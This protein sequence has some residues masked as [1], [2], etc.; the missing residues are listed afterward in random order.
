MRVLSNCYVSDL[1][2]IR[3]FEREQE[4]LKLHKRKTLTTN[5]LSLSLSL[6]QVQATHEE[7]GAS[8]P[9]VLLWKGVM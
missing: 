9:Q 1:M 5:S 3:H 7:E 6:S 2:L 8:Q 4:A